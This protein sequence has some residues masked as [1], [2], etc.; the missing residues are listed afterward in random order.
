MGRRALAVAVVV[1]IVTL[2][3]GSATTAVGSRRAA[4]PPAVAKG[5]VVEKGPVKGKPP[6]EL[7]RLF[8]LGKGLSVKGTPK[9][10]VKG[11]PK[12]ARRPRPTPSLPRATTTRPVTNL[13][14]EVLSPEVRSTPLSSSEPK[15][16][17]PLLAVLAGT[18]A[19]VGALFVGVFVFRR[20][21]GSHGA[22]DP[23]TPSIVDLELRWLEAMS[24]ELLQRRAD[25]EH[26]FA[27][28]DNASHKVYPILAKRTD[29]MSKASEPEAVDQN[30]GGE[31]TESRSSYA[32]L[33]DRV[34]SVL[35]RAQEVA[36]QIRAEA[37][38]EA[39]HIQ[40]SAKEAA[41][42]HTR[43]VEL[44]HTRIRKDAEEYAQEIRQTGEAYASQIRRET[45]EA[46][47][48]VL[49]EADAQARAIREAAEEMRKRIELVA[50]KRKA[51]LQ[52]ELGTLEARL[53]RLFNGLTT[54]AGQTERLLA[55]DD[56]VAPAGSLVDALDVQ[57]N[58]VA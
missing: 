28:S 46:A 27:G 13:S 34:A 20:R 33:G 17:F 49:S 30:P 2:E 56:E 6:S 29:S 15:S 4:P 52:S 43:E 9:T 1:L 7:W 22:L 10:A 26:S 53:E 48:K 39:A 14:P 54:M 51:E 11:T 44:E 5:P 8:P 16:T 24:T 18:A 3:A 45:D 47:R 57:R 35:E 58:T 42:A 41:E 23:P 36:E 25:R 32:A 40:S 12:T 38:A 37:E 55:G 50:Q 31:P 19:S 21:R